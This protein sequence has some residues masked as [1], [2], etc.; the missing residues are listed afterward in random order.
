VVDALAEKS[1]RWKDFGKASASRF[2]QISLKKLTESDSF[3]SHFSFAWVSPQES[4]S[5]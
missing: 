4:G 2:Q 5:F 3:Q 1:L